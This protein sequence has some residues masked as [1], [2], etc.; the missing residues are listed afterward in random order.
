MANKLQFQE[1]RISAVAAISFD[2]GLLDSLVPFSSRTPGY[3]ANCW[4][5]IVLLEVSLVMNF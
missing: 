2:S 4:I 5:E 3:E 1:Q